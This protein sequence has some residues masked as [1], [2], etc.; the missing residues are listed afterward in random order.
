M[1]EVV[2]RFSGVKTKGVEDRGGENLE[3]VGITF[4]TAMRKKNLT[5]DPRSRK[6]LRNMSEEAGGK[7][8]GKV[9]CAGGNGTTKFS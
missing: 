8:S 6:N 9:F 1:N 5:S 7:S 2:S 4:T 3:Q